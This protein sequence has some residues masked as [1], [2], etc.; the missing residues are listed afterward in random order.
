[1]ANRPLV[2]INLIIITA[3]HRFVAKEV[4]GIILDS[5]REV[6]VVFDVSKAVGFV[7]ASGK[8]VE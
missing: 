7:P 2:L 4:D 5:I 1:V 6:S 8:D 3:L